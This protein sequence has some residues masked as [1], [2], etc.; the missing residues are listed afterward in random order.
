[1]EVWVNF[2]YK[3]KEEVTTNLGM[4][5]GFTPVSVPPH[6][7]TTVGNVCDAKDAI[8]AS[9]V[10]IVTLFGHAHSHNTRFVVYWDKTDGSSETVYDTYDWAEAP[11]YTYNSV[12]QNP[13]SDPDAR[14]T[15][16]KSGILALAAGE[17]LR[18]ACDINNTTDNTLVGTNE[19]FSGE[20]C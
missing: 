8:A 18:F 10:R 11:T 12:V 16:G 20:M 17:R 6:T 4:L 13:V 1:R 2:I 7:Q 19:V 15:G 3:P 5:G 14:R 9:P